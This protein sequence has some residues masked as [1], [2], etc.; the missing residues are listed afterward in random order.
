MKLKLILATMLLAVAGMTTRA[1]VT[2]PIDG[3]TYYIYGYNPLNSIKTYLTTVGNAKTIYS[4]TLKGEDTRSFLWQCIAN[5]DGTY[6]FRNLYR[7][8]YLNQKTLSATAISFDLSKSQ[9]NGYVSMVSNNGSNDICMVSKHTTGSTLTALDNY[10]NNST[11]GTAYANCLASGYNGEWSGVFGL[12]EYA[13]QDIV[14]AMPENGKVYYLYGDNQTT[15]KTASVRIYHYVNSE[16]TLS[17]TKTQPTGVDLQYLWM[18]EVNGTSYKFRNLSSNTYL[19]YYNAVSAEGTS[20]AVSTDGAN[21]FGAVTIKSGS[22]YM[23]HQ[24][25][26]GSPA[27]AHADRIYNKYNE[28]YSSDYIFEECSFT[29]PL[30]GCYYYIYCDNYGSANGNIANFLYDNSGSFGVTSSPVLSSEAYVWKCIKNADGT[31]SFQNKATPTRYLAFHAITETAFAWT[32]DASKAVNDGRIPL[33]GN[34]KG[35]YPNVVSYEGVGTNRFMLIKPNGTTNNG[36]A[37]AKWIKNKDWSSDYVFLLHSQGDTPYYKL[38]VN[39][40]PEIGNTLALN[41]E[42]HG[43]SFSEYVTGAFTLAT[44]ETSGYTFNGFIDAQG[45]NIGT[46]YDCTGLTADKS[47]TASYSL[48]AICPSYGQQWYRILNASNKTLALA[49]NGEGLAFEATDITKA[50]Q[51]WCLVGTEESFS[52]YNKATGESKAYPATSTEIATWVF[53]PLSGEAVTLNLMQTGTFSV[54]DSRVDALTITAGSTSMTVTYI[55]GEPNKTYNFFLKDDETVTIATTTPSLRGVAVTITDGTGASASSMTNLAP[56]TTRNITYTLSATEARYLSY[57]TECYRIPAMATTKQGTLLAIYDQRPGKADVGRGE[58]DLV[59]RTSTDNGVTWS[60]QTMLLD[61]DGVTAN[62]TCGYGDAAL[63]ADRESNKIL[64]MCVEGYGNCD[65]SQSTRTKHIHSVRVWGEETSQGTITWDEPTDMEETMYNS[66]FPKSRAIFI[67]SGRIVQSTKVKVGN[68]YRIYCSVLTR[69][70]KSVDDTSVANCNFVIYSDDFGQTWNVLGGTTNNYASE[71]PIPSGADEPKV[72]ELPNG[73][74]VLASRVARGRI[75]NVFHFTDFD[76]DKTSGTWGTALTSMTADGGISNFDGGTNGEI[77]SVRALDVAQNKE[78]DLML[79]SMPF[80]NGRANVG[81]YYKALDSDATYTTE[82]FAANWTKAL[83]VST[84][85]S[86]YSTFSIQSDGR[87]AFFMEEAPQLGGAGYSM[88]YLPLSIDEITNGKY[89][90]LVN[91]RSGY[92]ASLRNAITLAQ[93]YNGKIGTGY[94]QYSSDDYTTEELTAAT[95]SAVTFLNGITSETTDDAILQ[96]ATTLWT[97]VNSITLNTPTVGKFYRIKNTDATPKYAKSNGAGNTMAHSTG[98]DG[99]ESIFFLDASRHLVAFANGAYTYDANYLATYEQTAAG[100]ADIVNFEYPYI[101]TDGIHALNIRVQNAT[102]NGKYWYSAASKID[103]WMSE[104]PAQCNFIIEDVTEI[105]VT[106]GST[107][108]STL[109]TPIPLSL[110]TGVKAYAGS[111]D[112]TDNVLRLSP[113]T[114]TIPAGT[115]VVLYGTQGTHLLRITEEAT[116]QPANDLIGSCT[117][118]AWTQGIY[119]M[120]KDKATGDVG[121]FGNAPTNGYIPGFKAFLQTAASV[122]GL[123]LDMETAIRTLSADKNDDSIY[124]LSGRKAE[125]PSKGIF[126]TNNRKYI[127]K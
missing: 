81:F 27:F 69:T 111:I 43:S 57:N 75:F 3:H 59:Y 117:A 98:G 18:C 51:I 73:D 97:R 21:V 88:T 41:G 14:S 92:I 55:A 17:Q 84:V 125:K 35:T 33:W 40:T 1:E 24:N 50:E 68:Y 9:V 5:S 122:K 2:A 60:D 31:Y 4:T 16:G 109:Y 95:T 44:N 82:T 86:A 36:Y 8:L 87:L 101:P 7:G 22:N 10:T 61:G 85:N 99:A 96:Q 106:I 115:A 100:T 58:T 39:S 62:L 12:E 65:F 26:N 79:L 108:Y 89:V 72:E 127:I 63:V 105:P 90:D 54:A 120:Q 28:M 121:F 66:L 119:T 64:L 76:S 67:G 114:G 118:T 78:V 49:P 34:A 104:P 70:E 47:L 91:P 113:L 45:Y 93:S 123:T 107:G 102:T 53:E 116:T 25:S 71:A 23:L 56:G 19:T 29:P 15:D 30:D 13:T 48:Q 124:D 42:T 32:L 37:D 52:L 20:F 126:I 77:Y 46:T 83:Q 74:I 80:G 6:T 11:S 94:G 103:R 38:T 112:A 110:P